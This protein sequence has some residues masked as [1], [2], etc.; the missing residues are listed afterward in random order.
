MKKIVLFIIITLSFSYVKAQDSKFEEKKESILKEISASQKQLQSI[1]ELGI[2][3]DTP[4]KF[5]TVI[6]SEPTPIKLPNS[7]GNIDEIKSEIK[8]ANWSQWVTDEE[9]IIKLDD[10]TFEEYLRENNIKKIVLENIILHN[11]KKIAKKI[12]IDF[13]D[14]PRMEFV[15]NLKRKRI[16]SFDLKLSIELQEHTDL[17]INSDI[18]SVDSL[19][20]ENIKIKEKTVS[21]LKKENNK[22]FNIYAL[23][24]NEL[25][26]KSIGMSSISKLTDKEIS[27]YKSILLFLTDLKTALKKNKFKD[28]KEFKE[29]I[30]KKRPE[31]IIIPKN[32]K[33]K[34]YN[35]DFAIVPKK[36]LFR[37]LGKKTT[38]EM[39]VSFSE[40]SNDNVFIVKSS[41][42]KYGLTDSN[43]NWILDP[44]YNNLSKNKYF[45][46]FY[47][48]YNKTIWISPDNKIKKYDFTLTENGLLIQKWFKTGKYVSTK[49]Q[50]L[51]DAVNRKV[52]LPVDMN[53]HIDAYH[54]YYLVKKNE[55]GVDLE[56]LYDLEGNLIFDFD[57][58]E[59]ELSVN[60]VFKIIKNKNEALYKLN[61]INNKTTLLTSREYSSIDAPYYRTTIEKLNEDPLILA[62]KHNGVRDYI[63]INGEIAI[64]GE[65]YKRV[66]HS[67]NRFIVKDKKDVFSILDKHG[68]LIKRLNKD[69][70]PKSGYSAYLLQAK[71]KKTGLYGYLDKKGELVIPFMYSSA[72]RFVKFS[73]ES[74]PKASVST[75]DKQG[76][77]TSYFIDKNNKVIGKKEFYKKEDQVEHSIESN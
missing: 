51:F 10:Y 58:Q 21:F 47:D 4:I 5:S 7:D 25:F 27:Y 9:T 40:N 64:D 45:S 18:T 48:A 15:L 24:E 68:K 50:G 66:R 17:I 56:G 6:P 23:D 61:T 33:S 52:I 65:K 43:G 31:E 11:N 35:F 77:E 13:S 70:I 69:I 74:L 71:S 1:I 57:N 62:N 63:T 3:N 29:Y 38:S 49:G 55:K 60:H 53:N 14:Y 34:I 59:I 75:V 39:I 73:G 12:E 36:M 22:K 28:E 46:D 41:N 76:N 37:V 44:I 30:D 2:L 72:T 54:S 67:S 20:I 26:Y 8:K 32:Q 16:K 42:H 19:Q